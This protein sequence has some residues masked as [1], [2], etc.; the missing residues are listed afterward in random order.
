MAD[1]LFRAGPTALTTSA[2]D[3]YTAPGGTEA[4]V[5]DVH[6]CNETGTT[7]TFTLSVGNDG[8]GKRLYYECEVP[9]GR[10]FQRT[11]AIHLAAGEKIQA[12]AS[13]NSALTITLGGVEST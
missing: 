1:A 4:T 6:V 7:Q 12:L 5:R 3:I 2:A 8:A 9:P 10:P 13:A 11:G